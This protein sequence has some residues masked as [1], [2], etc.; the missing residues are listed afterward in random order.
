M[1]IS[2]NSSIKASLAFLGSTWDT[3]DITIEGFENSLPLSQSCA[4]SLSDDGTGILFY[5]EKGG[6]LNCYET[7]D[8]AE[9]WTNSATLDISADIESAYF[10]YLSKEEKTLTV[11]KLKKLK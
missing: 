7:N 6:L 2:Q 3:K 5:L 1:A 9:T 11:Q 10:V 4:I 8:G